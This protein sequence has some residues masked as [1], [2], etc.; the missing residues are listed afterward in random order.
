MTP[1]LHPCPIYDFA[2]GSPGRQNG[3][4]PLQFGVGCKTRPHNGV[5]ASYSKRGGG[6]PAGL[7]RASL[8]LVH[9]HPGPPP[10]GLGQTAGRRHTIRQTHKQVRP[11]WATKHQPR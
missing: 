5:Q 6:L 10:E 3:P 4:E 1:I 2:P 11:P 9:S 8:R 7:S